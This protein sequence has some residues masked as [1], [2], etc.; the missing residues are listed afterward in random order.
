MIERKRMIFDVLPEVQ[1][2][3]KLRAIKNRCTTGEIISKAVELA[4][5]DDIKE[6]R[7]ALKTRAGSLANDQ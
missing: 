7:E 6:A 2:A 5:P 4:F 1:I 3:I